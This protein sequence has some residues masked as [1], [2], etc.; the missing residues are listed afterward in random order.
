[1]FICFVRPGKKS[2]M[3]TLCET[4]RDIAHEDSRKLAGEFLNDWDAIVRVVETPSYPLTYNVA[5]QF[6]AL[7]VVAQN[8]VGFAHATS[9]PSDC[10][11]AQC[12]RY[13]ALKTAEPMGF[14]CSG[15][16]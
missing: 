4:H 6:A 9:E 1:M 16:G 2:D 11:A 10:V 5:A 12:D 8:H 14:Y 7:G 13:C 15:T 3:R